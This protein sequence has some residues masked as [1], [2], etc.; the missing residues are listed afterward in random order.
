M[1]VLTTV[2]FA[3]AIGTGVL[4]QGVPAPDASQPPRPAPVAVET[5]A[6]QVREQWREI[7]SRYPPEVGRILKMDPTMLSNQPYLAQYPAIQQFLAAHPE[8]ARNPTFY[9]EFVRQSS[10]FTVPT[11]PESRAIAMWSDILEGIS[12]FAVVVFISGMVAWLIK[13]MLN[14]RRW[15]RTARVQTEVHNKLLDRFAGTNELLTYI[16]TPAGRRFLEAAPIPVEA[17]TDRPIGAPLS[18]ILWSVQAGIVLVVG[19]FGFQYVSG[20]VVPEVGQGLWTMGVLGT[21]FG[22]GFIIAGAF[23]YVMSRRLGLLDPPAP[24][25][26]PERGDSAVV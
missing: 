26:D 3:A 12:V 4:A 21:A 13:T 20:S 14:H 10:D 7:L 16:Q 1:R 17:A 5:D 24:L 22:I 23:S 19:G 6:R 9:L 18:R 25:R 8:I 11:D 2:L 15:L